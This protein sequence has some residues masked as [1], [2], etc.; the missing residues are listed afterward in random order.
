M[1]WESEAT[2]STVISR[3]LTLTVLAALGGGA[4]GG[5]CGGAD[6]TCAAGAAAAIRSSAA[7]AQ[8]A[9]LGARITP[10]LL[11]HLSINRGV[12]VGQLARRK[13]LKELRLLG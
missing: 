6:G 5:F 1:P 4:A 13:R 8:M 3:V 12:I 9:F 11:T 2:I 10:S 7:P